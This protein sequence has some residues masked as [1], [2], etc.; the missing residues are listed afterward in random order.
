MKSQEYEINTGKG[1]PTITG[2]PIEFPLLEKEGIYF[3]V[4]RKLDTEAHKQDPKGNWIVSEVE[5]G[6][7]IGFSQALTR[8]DAIEY[9]L[10][11]LSKLGIKK[12]KE[13][14]KSRTE[15]GNK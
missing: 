14:I 5:T 11:G 3:F 4:H 1:K 9:A 7:C 6:R 8:E 2:Y 13:V 12:V 10:A 15:G